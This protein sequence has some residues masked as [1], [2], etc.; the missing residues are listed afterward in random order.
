MRA[1]SG[2]RAT[3]LVFAA[4]RG[5]ASLL[6]PSAAALPLLCRSRS[7]RRMAIREVVNKHLVET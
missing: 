6:G 7:R 2:G 5:E 3:A 1:D 4:V